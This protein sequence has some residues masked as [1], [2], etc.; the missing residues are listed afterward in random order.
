MKGVIDNDILE[1]FRKGENAAF[2]QIFYRYYGELFLFAKKLTGSAEEAEDITVITF[3]KLFSN[4]VNFET[5][6]NIKAFLYIAVRNAS[7]SYLRN[8]KWKNEKQRLFADQMQSDLLFDY[9][10]G[11]RSDL[12]DRVNAAIE[13]LPD[14]CK[15][16]FK[17]MYFDG[18]TANE[19][20]E[21]L[22]L[23][24]STVFSHKQYALKALRL[25]LGE[26]SPSI[27]WILFVLLST[28]TPFFT[29]VHL[30]SA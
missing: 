24:A 27:A 23:S 28:E 14:R 17:K 2:Q 12:L 16:V 11:M 13:Q 29:R 9:E 10:Y 30:L 7:F 20:A 8:L 5:E 21:E 25:M 19:V 26:N 18:L 4:S 15:L 6:E 22:K 1:R 3:N